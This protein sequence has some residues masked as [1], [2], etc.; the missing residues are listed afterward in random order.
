[1]S[2]PLSLLHQDGGPSGWAASRSLLFHC[3][4]AWL[5][6]WASWLLFFYPIWV[7]LALLSPFPFSVLGESVLFFMSNIFIYFKLAEFYTCYVQ[8]DV[9]RYFSLLSWR[10]SQ[11]C[12]LEAFPPFILFWYMIFCDKMFTNSALAKHHKFHCVVFSSLSPLFLPSFPFLSPVQPFTNPL[13]LLWFWET[14]PGPHTARQVLFYWG[15][16]KPCAFTSSHFRIFQLLLWLLPR[17]GSHW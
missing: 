10:E 6:H 8:P 13:L 2:V 9:L 7:S 16:P 1:M 15:D 17:S 14:D 11:S 12:W 4:P 3:S 5:P